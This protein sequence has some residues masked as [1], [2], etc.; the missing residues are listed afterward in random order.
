MK[1]FALLTVSCLAVSAALSGCTSTGGSSGQVDGYMNTLADMAFDQNRPDDE[2]WQVLQDAMLFNRATSTYLWAMP[3]INT[4][5]M[6]EAS[7][8]QFGKGYNVLPIWKGRLSA[9]T[10]VT[11]PNSDVLYAMSYLDLSDGPLVVEAPAKLQGMFIDVWQRPIDVDGSPHKGDVR[12]AG[13]DG[14]K[15]GKF[16]LLPPD[17]EGKIPKGHYVYRSRTNTVFVFLRGFYEDP[18]NLTPASK[19]MEMT[20]VYPL[21]QASSAKKNGVS[22]WHWR[23]S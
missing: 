21:S 8:A 14:G 22:R 11:T 4:L 7:E 23:G 1:L 2:Q 20:K 13:P 9:K 12:L 18:N 3:L 19:H 5:G 17:Y 16:L 6:Q 15:G 10:Q